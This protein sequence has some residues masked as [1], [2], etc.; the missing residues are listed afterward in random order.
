MFGGDN[1][2]KTEAAT[3]RHRQKARQKGQVAK[4]REI[5][6]V[7]ILMCALAVFSFLGPWMFWKISGAM[8]MIFQG[9]GAFDIDTGSLHSVFLDIFQQI[10]IILT[11]LMFTVLVAGIAGN[12]LQFGFLLTSKPLSP[13]LSRLD[14]IKGIRKLL[15][16]RSLVELVKSLFKVVFIGIVAFLVIRGELAGIPS[17]VQ[18][19]VGGILAFIAKVSFK[20]CFYTCLAL[21]VLAI[22]DYTYQRWQHEKDLRMTKQEVKDDYK[23]TEG[24][25]N[26]KARIRSIQREMARARM[27]EQVPDADVIVTNPTRLA[28]AL[29]FDSEVMIAPKVTAK[30]AGYIAEKIKEIAKENDVPIVENKPLAQALYKTVDLGEF[31]PIDLY[32]AVAGVLAYVYKIKGMAGRHKA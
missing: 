28:I 3:P 4:S 26:V 32:R 19:D 24:D 5:P 11:P 27:M 31:V 12:I 30:G 23:Q 17:I 9:I 15:S 2:E 8:K 18:L 6:S 25:P 16:L 29:K 20:V 21:I 1:Q 13:D 7:L 10:A 14:P 22:L